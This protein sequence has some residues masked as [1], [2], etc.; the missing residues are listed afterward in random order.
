MDVPIDLLEWEVF[1]PEQYKVKDFGGDVMAA[2]LVPPAFQE[3]VVVAEYGAAGAAGGAIGGIVGPVSSAAPV[4]PGQ[5]GGTVVDS[6]GA[7]VPGAHVTLTNSDTGFA[8]S[9]A[10]DASGR[11]LVSNIPAGR[12]KIR[13]DASGFN[14][15]VENIN[16]DSSR[17]AEYPITLRVGAAMET[18]TVEAN[19]LQSTDLA[20]NGRNYLQLQQLEANAKKQEQNAA[21]ANVMN[22]QRRVAGV[23]PV[24][25]EVPRTGTSFQFVRPLVLDE[26]TKVTFSYKSK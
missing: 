21:S 13:V 1:L 12:G 24:A 7:V 26:E 20:L 17:A 10:T 25:I 8:T 6:S 15:T 2:N 4:S 14:P 23:L 16:Y 11:W 5:L 9:T 19:A 22:L 3:S 18:I